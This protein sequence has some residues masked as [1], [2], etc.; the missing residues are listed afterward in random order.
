[1]PGPL[2]APQLAQALRAFLPLVRVLPLVLR[3]VAPHLLLAAKHSAPLA[4]VARVGVGLYAGLMRWYLAALDGVVTLEERRA[5]VGVVLALELTGWELW[6][7]FRRT[8]HAAPVA[9]PRWGSGKR[10]RSRT[11]HKKRRER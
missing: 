3:A 5:V 9:P 2:S 7:E 6:Q 11:R 10:R 4:V 8:L 1:M